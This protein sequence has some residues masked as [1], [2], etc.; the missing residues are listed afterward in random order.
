MMIEKMTCTLMM[1]IRTSGLSFHQNEKSPYRDLVPRE[2]ITKTNFTFLEDIKKKVEIFT[3]I[4]SFMT[5]RKK[6]GLMLALLNLARY[7]AKE[8]IIL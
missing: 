3:K 8:L 5:F 1:S 4:Y 2:S 6:P 7:L